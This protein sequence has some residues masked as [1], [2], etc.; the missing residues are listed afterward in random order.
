M[1]KDWKTDINLTS[2]KKRKA[3]A[4][5]LRKKYL[6]IYTESYCKKGYFF[7]PDRFDCKWHYLAK[8]KA[9]YSDPVNQ[10]RL[11]ARL[12]RIMN[13]DTA[14]QRLDAIILKENEAQCDI[15]VALFSDP[16]YSRLLKPRKT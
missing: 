12:K 11:L 5:F 13:K 16:S 1:K 9:W 3:F 7:C 15:T 2:R 6:C 14:Q 4:M 10:K 8:R